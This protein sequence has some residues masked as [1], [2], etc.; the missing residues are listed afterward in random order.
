M[1]L[2]QKNCTRE[3]FKILLKQEHLYDAAIT[4]AVFT[5]ARGNIVVPNCIKDTE[6]CWGY[7]NDFETRTNMPIAY[8]QSVFGK[9]P[10]M[11]IPDV[12]QFDRNTV[13]NHVNH[14]FAKESMYDNHFGKRTCGLNHAVMYFRELSR[15]DAKADANADTN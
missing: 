4:D 3:T 11:F 7:M 10:W 5:F 14:Y 13:N 8:L 12:K 15:T 1:I 9:L 2:R 6:A